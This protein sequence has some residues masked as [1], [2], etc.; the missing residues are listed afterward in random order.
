VVFVFV[1]IWEHWGADDTRI[2]QQ[3]VGS[4]A[5]TK[6]CRSRGRKSHGRLPDRNSGLELPSRNARVGRVAL[7]LLLG[8]DTAG[9]GWL[10]NICELRLRSS[11]RWRFGVNAAARYSLWWGAG[12]VVLVSCRGIYELDMRRGSE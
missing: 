8:S 7:L 3:A 2:D 5:C 10:R 9:K 12:V 4:G 11:T 6:S 1:R